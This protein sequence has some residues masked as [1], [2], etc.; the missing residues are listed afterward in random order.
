MA[1]LSTGGA[2]SL[3]RRLELS[4]TRGAHAHELAGQRMPDLFGCLEAKPMLLF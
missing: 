3:F 1:T 4:Y 2:L